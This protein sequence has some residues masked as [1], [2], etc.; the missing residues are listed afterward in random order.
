MYL[1]Q[2][3]KVLLAGGQFT[4]SGFSLPLP[5]SFRAYRRTLYGL[6][7]HAA[8]VHRTYLFDLL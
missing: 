3:R 5:N 2:E 7:S 6:Q 8:Q 1:R 4:F